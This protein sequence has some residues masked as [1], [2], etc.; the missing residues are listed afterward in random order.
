MSAGRLLTWRLRRIECTAQY[1][2]QRTMTLASGSIQMSSTVRNSVVA[3]VGTRSS[4]ERGC[5]VEFTG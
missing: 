5:R 3:P 1:D 4:A 2:L